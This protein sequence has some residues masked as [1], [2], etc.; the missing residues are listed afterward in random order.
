VKKKITRRIRH[1]WHQLIE[2]VIHLQPTIHRRLHPH[3]PGLRRF[4]SRLARVVYG[5]SALLLMALA[6]VY[7]VA[8]LWLPAIAEKK[9]EIEAWL[10]KKTAQKI[11]IEQL[12]TFWR[13]LYPGVRLSNVR[14]YAD[15]G[16]TVPTVH[17]REL[18]LSLDWIPL[19]WGEVRV[20]RLYVLG[21]RLSLERLKDGRFRVSGFAAVEAK[22]ADGAGEPFIAMLFRQHLL[23]IADGELQWRDHRDPKRVLHFRNVNLSLV[24]RGARHRLEFRAAFPARL[25]RDCSIEADI[26]GNPFLNEPWH[27]Y[28][29]LRAVGLDVSALPAI[30]AER[31][32]TGLAGQFSVDLDSRWRDG[33][34]QQVRGHVR[35][36]DLRM[37]VPQLAAPAVLKQA[38]GLVRWRRRAAGWEL[39]ARE[40]KF[41]LAG[42][43]WDAGNLHI[44]Q[45]G[46]GGELDLKR[47]NLNDLTAFAVS[48][49]PVAGKDGARLRQTLQLIR[50]L[51]VHGHLADLRGEWK[52]PI[53]KPGD[54]RF[55]TD[56][57]QLGLEPVG[58]SPGV[59]NLTGRLSIHPRGGE[60]LLDSTRLAV[61]MPRLFD[62]PLEASRA[63]GR[64]KLIR[65][66]S[67]WLLDGEAMELE[68]PD[69]QGKGRLLLRIPHDRTQQ[70]HLKLRVEFRNGNG[71]H[72]A[73]Y[74]PKTIPPKTLAWL[75]RSF[76]SGR[77]VDGTLLYDGQA[78]D[79]PFRQGQG[80]FEI[81]ARATDMVYA[82]LPGW[83]PLTSA[84]AELLID[85]ARV[86]VRGRGR[87]G[88]LQAD[89]IQVETGIK[90]ARLVKVGLRVHGP[91]DDFLRTLQEA[92]PAPG[93]TWK[94]AIP[95]TARG[96]GNG[97]LNLKIEV[98]LKRGVASIAG[99][100]SLRAGAFKLPNAQVTLDGLT[101]RV[102]FT[103]KGLHDGRL[104]GRLFGGDVTVRIDSPRHGELRVGAHG[105]VTADGLKSTLGP[106]M[107]GRISG[108]IP[109]GASYRII[110][111]VPHLQAQADLPGLKSSLPAP[112]NR[113]DGLTRDKLVI[114]TLTANRRQH[115]VDLRAGAELHGRL[116]FT[117]ENEGWRFARGRVA[118]GYPRTAL[119]P[120][121]GLHVQARLAAFNLDPWKQFRRPVAKETALPDVFRRVSVDIGDLNGFE[122][123]FG[124]LAIDLVRGR[125]GW[126]GTI[127]GR[128]ANGRLRID[129][130][131]SPR[132]IELELA[133]L[134]LPEGLPG[135]GKRPPEHGDP[136]RLPSVRLR[137][138]E[139]VWK[140][141]R[142]GQLELTAEPLADGWSVGRLAL[143]RPEAKFM[144]SGTWRFVKDRHTSDFDLRIHSDNAGETL[145]AFG[146]PDQL[147]R[148]KVDIQARLSWLGTPADFS[149]RI[150]H[151]EVELKAVKGSFAHRADKPAA[152]GGKHA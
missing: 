32:P 37:P 52:G 22:E 33:R 83:K 96:S 6:V 36:A 131:G 8:R 114:R 76:V 9:P 126:Q 3:L 59:R 140:D 82:F 113:P 27:G 146:I 118:F 72:A 125:R 13:G 91:F 148:G 98:P 80:R 42:A 75:R 99:D 25:C 123:A 18:H 1:I 56:V 44:E 145:T 63:S 31:L 20:D 122:R 40:L 151:G 21:P 24:N 150:V 43:G 69:A 116:L 11:R 103:E 67:H 50:Q 101:G 94:A 73:R 30:L 7:L 139:L 53:V 2:A 47:I 57:L 147:D 88:G 136:R 58:K 100:F 46:D 97:E 89:N 84:T 60:F 121:P 128:T 23:E 117:N 49:R 135:A 119:P 95:P 104:E 144:I 142:L 127:R 55:E 115:H 12:D 107:A 34:V 68:H 129:N 54:F 45:S 85:H 48:L 133:R 105:V 64:F 29:Q 108:E 132:R 16:R 134:R 86:E 35:A 141:R 71:V 120:T 61:Q 70:P 41:G 111:G 15:G 79:F 138:Q 65:E 143:T 26:N 38:S 92:R 28:L 19:L 112:L 51:N 77:V 124:R 93:Q 149:P 14:V 109:W 152:K 5:T 62:Q 137:A 81:R 130:L 74:Y 106:A 78:K 66:E 102:A 39:D 4:G 17:L 110:R 10:S 90:G 87:L